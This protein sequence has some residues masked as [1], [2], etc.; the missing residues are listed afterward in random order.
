MVLAALDQNN[1]SH[2]LLLLVVVS[3]RHILK[4][5]SAVGSKSVHLWSSAAGRFRRV[6]STGHKL[7]WSWVSK[8]CTREMKDK[9]HISGLSLVL[10]KWLDKLKGASCAE[11]TGPGEN[12]I[13]CSEWEAEWSWA[14]LMCVLLFLSTNCQI[15][16]SL[17]TLSLPVLGVIRD[18]DEIVL[19]LLRTEPCHQVHGLFP[20]KEADKDKTLTLLARAALLL[21]PTSF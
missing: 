2:Y 5:S 9:G 14:W 10:A 19:Q 11:G 12:P 20:G 13:H 21:S 7:F 16:F 15:H 1:I 6:W 4:I 8:D 18:T 3:F 17:I